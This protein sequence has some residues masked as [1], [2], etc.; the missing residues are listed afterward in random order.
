MAKALRFGS[1]KN[2]ADGRRGL[3]VSP[4]SRAR[5]VQGI[6]SEYNL[7]SPPLLFDLL[8]LA[9]TVDPVKITKLEAARRQLEQAIELYFNGGDPVSIHTLAWAAFTV[10]R[11][12]NKHRAGPQMLVDKI[13][14][15]MASEYGPGL[16]KRFRQAMTF[17][18]HAEEDPTDELEFW[19]DEAEIVIL[20][21]CSRFQVMAGIAVPSFLVF[22][23]WYI[24]HDKKHFFESP[25]TKPY[26]ELPV[27]E[28]TPENRRIIYREQMKLATQ[29]A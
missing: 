2:F 21:A 20:D 6:G 26:L 14:D 29:S 11:D 10:I 3:L 8:G 9:A 17:F 24:S 12:V 27:I 13:S 1:L 4:N 23:R 15:Q 16:K 19:P 22:R 18:K 7:L 5:S 25:E 28:D